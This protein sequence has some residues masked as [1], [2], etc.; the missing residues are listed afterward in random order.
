MSQA[1][2][3]LR[4]VLERPDDG[5]RH[6]V[7]AD[8]LEEQG[9][10]AHAGRAELFRLLGEWLL[11]RSRD[12]KRRKLSSRARELAVERPELFGPLP[13]LVDKHRPL[14]KMG[15]AL[16]VF[17]GAAIPGPGDDPLLER[18]VWRGTLEQ[19]T[20]VFP[21]TLTVR[22]R[23]ANRISGDVVQDFRP[24]FHTRT[25]ARM[26]F[27]G[28]VLCGRFA[29]VADRL[30]G[31]MLH[32]VLFQAQTR[33]DALEGTWQ[34]SRNIPSVRLPPTHQGTFR[35]ERSRGKARSE[36]PWRRDP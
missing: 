17:A 34:V 32:P 26:T 11:L 18:S 36:A 15:P 4:A 12:A 23:K 14:L 20:W 28:A 29:A 24:R 19:T 31:H 6:L 13:S 1:E 30:E 5:A 16:V 25:I 7:L 21:T 22:R 33:D 3:L 27:E 35:L 10:P 8:W 9:D 2:D